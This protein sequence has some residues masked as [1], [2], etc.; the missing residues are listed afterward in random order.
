MVND[1]VIEKSGNIK[2]LGV[3]LDK[4]LIQRSHLK[5]LKSTLSRSCF[6][7]LKLRYYLDTNTLKMVYYSQFYP[8]IQYCISA[9][10]DAAS[11]H[12]EL[13]VCMPKR[14]WKY[15]CCVLALTPTN[16][17]YWICSRNKY[18]NL[19]SLFF[20]QYLMFCMSTLHTHLEFSASQVVL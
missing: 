11:C 20:V 18:L 2:Y 6:V 15:V 5:S 14:I 4:K 3:V 13:I 9:Q 8:H 10:G 16:P 12:L 7:M 19:Y 1:F 17:C